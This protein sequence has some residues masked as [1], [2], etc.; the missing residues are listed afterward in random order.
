[1]KAGPQPAQS[2]GPE[3]QGRGDIGSDG[4][5]AEPL[6]RNHEVGTAQEAE[7]EKGFF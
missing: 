5:E 7:D 2:H 4:P 1:M 3:S 6:K